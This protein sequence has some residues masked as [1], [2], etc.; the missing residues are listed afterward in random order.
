MEGFYRQK[1]DGERKLLT[2]ERKGLLPARTSGEDTP[3]GKGS[4]QAEHLPN[5]HQEISD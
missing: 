4:H 3:D 5:A 1:E 2:K